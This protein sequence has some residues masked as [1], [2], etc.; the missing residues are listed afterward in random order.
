MSHQINRHFLSLWQRQP[1]RKLNQFHVQ[2]QRKLFL[3]NYPMCLS[4]RN[5]PQG[6]NVQFCWLSKLNRSK[7]NTASSKED[8]DEDDPGFYLNK[9]YRR[10]RVINYLLIHSRKRSSDSDEDARSNSK[11]ARY[12]FH[13]L[14]NSLIKFSDPIQS[15]QSRRSLQANLQ[16]KNKRKLKHRKALIDSLS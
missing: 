15:G 5:Y 6:N 9:R 2:Q 13:L 16:R 8:S 11:K 3:L 4:E 10:F 1:R 12:L 14:R 7:R